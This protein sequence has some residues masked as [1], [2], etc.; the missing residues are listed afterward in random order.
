MLR[1]VAY[2][3]P[4]RLEQVKT[5]IAS[6]GIS[7]MSAGDVRGTGN[8]AEASTWFGGEQQFVAMPIKA[9]IEA[10]VPD[11]MMEEMIA[12]IIE[13]ARTGEPGDGKIFVEPVLDA[14]RVRTRESGSDAI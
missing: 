9:K 14:I 3:R 1:I 4:H 7:G 6:L 8:S 11:E 10:V 12:A 5:A 13:G 2:I